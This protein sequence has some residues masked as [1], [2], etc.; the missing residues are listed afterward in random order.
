MR[1]D[2]IWS[3]GDAALAQRKQALVT[4][5]AALRAQCAAQA[6]A[7]LQPVCGWVDRAG[8]LVHGVKRHPWLVLGA[9]A[10]LLM[11]GRRGRM[12]AGG[13]AWRVLLDAWAL[14]RRWGPL[15]LTVWRALAA[16]RPGEAEGGEPPQERFRAAAVSRGRAPTAD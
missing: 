11:L 15:G 9:G 14:A 1:W 4:R 2:P 12:R 16:S 7:L 13:G 8:K 3:R 10:G 6:D 5:S